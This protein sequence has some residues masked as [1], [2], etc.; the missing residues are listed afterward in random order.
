MIFIRYCYA[1]LITRDYT[2]R[3]A[4]RY[5]TLI[6][7]TP[8]PICDAI[9]GRLIAAIDMPMLPLISRATSAMSAFISLHATMMMIFSLIT[10]CA[11]ACWRY[12]AAA[13]YCHWLV[14]FAA[15]AAAAAD[16]AA[17]ATYATRM[18]LMII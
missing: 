18:P 4:T 12:A 14:Y 6:D 15:A 2:A 7:D 8:P 13:A 1:R 11:I 3:V 17:D 16:G 9:V 5:A 10:R